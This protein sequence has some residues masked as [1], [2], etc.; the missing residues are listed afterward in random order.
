MSDDSKRDPA[1]PLPH[2]LQPG[3]ILEAH[4]AVEDAIIARHQSPGHRGGER[5]H[6][7]RYPVLGAA[8]DPVDI[9]R[10]RVASMVIVPEHPRDEP[11][12]V[13]IPGARLRDAAIALA[14]IAERLNPSDATEETG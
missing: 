5:T 8:P 4:A 7:P 14:V 1:F 3:E 13:S 2:I 10:G 11:R 12:V 6:R 9:E